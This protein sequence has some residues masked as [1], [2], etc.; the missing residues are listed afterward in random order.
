VVFEAVRELRPLGVGVNLQ[1]NAVRELDD[2]GIGAE[3]LDRVGL[4]AR[5]WAL[6]GLNGNDIYTEPRGLEAGYRW[7]QYAVHR[8]QFHVLLAE[9]F[10]RRAGEGALRLGHRVTGYENNRDG[11]VTA[12]VERSDGTAVNETGTLL[13]GADGIHS[14]VR[15]QMHPD[16][17]P[18]HWG[19]AVMWRGTTRARPIRTGS[20]FASDSLAMALAVAMESRRETLERSDAIRHLGLW[21]ERGAIGDAAWRDERTGQLVTRDLSIAPDVIRETANQLLQECGTTIRRLVAGLSMPD[22]PEGARRAIS[23]TLAAYAMP[24]S[25]AGARVDSLLERYRQTDGF[26]FDNDGD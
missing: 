14:A 26:T 12:L 19:G 18:I 11:T 9:T 2:L 21:P 23:F 5:E 4:P 6:V 13:V 15:A 3:A 24:T 17:P 22:W 20:S 25:G 1:P 10:R 8:G 16:Q 7:P